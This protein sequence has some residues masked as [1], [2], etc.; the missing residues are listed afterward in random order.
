MSA[1]SKDEPSDRDAK[2]STGLPREAVRQAKDTILSGTGY[3]HPPVHSQFKKGQSGNPKGRPKSQGL[4]DGRSLSTDELVLKLAERKVTVREGGETQEIPAIEAVLRAQYV[5]ATKGNSHAQRHV[6]ERYDQAKRRERQ[7]I[8]DS[9][10]FWRGYVA[11]AHKEIAE[12]EALGETPPEPLPH[13]DDVVIDVV[14][15]VR[16]TG[17]FD[18][19]GAAK[20]RETC[21]LRDIL[22]LQDALDRRLMGEPDGG[23]PLDGPGTALAFAQMLNDSLPER[24]RLSDNEIVLRSMRH[25]TLPKRQLLKEVYQAWRRFGRAQPRGKTFPP[26]RYA[27]QLADNLAEALDLLREGEV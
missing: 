22:F 8:A 21:K 23:D 9:N 15:G 16:F 13:P 10:D 4:A 19:E 11:A 24:H 17:P 20:L 6:I 2:Q 5:S 7:E 1:S 3:K 12:A 26:L 27:M 14:K 25:D 18:E